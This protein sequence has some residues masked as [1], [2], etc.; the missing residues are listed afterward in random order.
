MEG[1]D[2]DDEVDVDFSGIHAFHE[3][4]DRSHRTPR[5]KHIIVDK[6]D[7]VGDD[8]VAMNLDCVFAILFV[9]GCA[10]R[11]GGQL[12]GLAGGNEA[13]TEFKGTIEPAINPRL[14]IPTTLVIPLSRY[15]CERSHPIMWRARGSLNAVVRSQNKIPF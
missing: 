11:I 8:C 7:V 9:V 6:H 12:S 14:S 1:I 15:S 2:F 13:G 5:S 3:F 10:D 4:V